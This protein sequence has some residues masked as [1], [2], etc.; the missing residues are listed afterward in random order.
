MNSSFLMA[1]ERHD[2]GQ[3]VETLDELIAEVT[4]AVIRTGKKGKVA[5]NM[6]IAPN[7]DRGIEVTYETKATAPQ[8]AF[9]KSFYFRAPDGGLS[10]TP[11][12]EEAADLLRHPNAR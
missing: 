2:E 11:P 6:S 4:S 9:S 1:L 5:L 8:L 3:V 7:G 10:R 12:K